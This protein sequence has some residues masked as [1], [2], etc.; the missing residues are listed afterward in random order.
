MFTVLVA[1]LCEFLLYWPFNSVIS[2]CRSPLL[3]TALAV[4]LNDCLTA[5]VVLRQTSETLLVPYD[6]FAELFHHS[7]YWEQ[8]PLSDDL[9]PYRQIVYVWVVRN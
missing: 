5:L 3:L 4:R 2:T 8:A 9:S 1:P 7:G 6:F